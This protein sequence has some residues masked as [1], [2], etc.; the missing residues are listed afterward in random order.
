MNALFAIS[1]PVTNVLWAKETDVFTKVLLIVGGVLLM[2]FASQLSVPFQ[3]VPLTFQ[4]SAVILIGMAYGARHGA[5][6][7]LA[8]LAAGFCGLP[9]FADY[10]AGPQFFVGP[11]GGYLLGFLP[12]VYLSGYLMK[13]GWGHSLITSFLAALFGAGVIFLFG[14]MVLANF[15]GG[16]QNAIAVGITPF[17]ISEPMKL[18]VVAALATGLWKKNPA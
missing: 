7:I 18:L 17:L 14:V 16:W 13:H 5:Y 4:S 2:A 3:P 9:V 11:T 15:T 1:T 6:V 12:A 8:Y 10:S